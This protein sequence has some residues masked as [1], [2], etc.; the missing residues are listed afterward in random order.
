MN[1][2]SFDLLALSALLSQSSSGR[3]GSEVYEH[4]KLG[5]ITDQVDFDLSRV[6]DT[7]YR[8]YPLHWAEM[9]YL[10]LRGENRYLYADA[11][12]AE[13]KQV[14][15]ELNDA[16]VRVSVLDSAIY[17]MTLPGTDPV[18]ERPAYADP[19]H[20]RL[21][22]QLEDLKRA[23]DGAHA[24]GTNRIRLFTFRRVANPDAIFDRIL[25]ELQRAV[26]I[27]K[28]HDVVLLV[29]NEYDTNT[30]MGREI[31]NLFKAIPDS[32][33]MHNWDPCNSYESGEVPFPTVWN[34]IDHS[35]IS[36]IHLKDARGKE[37]KPIGSGEIDFAGQLR[38][39]TR[40]GFS[41]T[42]SLET[43]YRDAQQDA[44]RSSVESMDGLSRLLRRF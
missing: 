26:T 19:A 29:E 31:A 16:G 25:E 40:I 9:R 30:A 35:R 13:L 32:H 1:R 8:R 4:W 10:R 37:W 5:V 11:T 28:Q 38:A 39:L 24:V 33:L 2:R 15:R 36:H 43:R 3:S 41:G 22:R 6:L 21:D 27:A 14:R 12:L 17:K 7:F 34:E 23:A 20:E 44:Y 42:L 18:G